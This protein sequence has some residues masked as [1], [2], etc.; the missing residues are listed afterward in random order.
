MLPHRRRP[1]VRR[2]HFRWL[3]GRESV[4]GYESSPGKIRH[5]C[6]RCGSHI[7]SEKSGLDEFILRVATLD[8]DPGMRPVVHIWTSHDVPWLEEVDLPKL[9]EGF[10]S[11]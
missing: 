5:F 6:K 7:V 11:T 1:R 10:S 4:A 9:A 8:S 2:E 3:L